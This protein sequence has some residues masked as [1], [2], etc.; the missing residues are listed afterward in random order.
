MYNKANAAIINSKYMIAN[1]ALAIY[2]SEF[3]PK[4]VCITEMNKSKNIT[5]SSLTNN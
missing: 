1:T 4:N 3:S 5:S 2:I